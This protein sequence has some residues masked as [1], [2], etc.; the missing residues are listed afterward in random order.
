MGAMLA[1][2]GILTGDEVAA[3][4]IRPWRSFAGLEF[5]LRF[6][7]GLAGDAGQNKVFEPTVPGC[8]RK[9]CGNENYILDMKR[10]RQED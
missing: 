7:I 8:G 5:L 9:T 10:P 3:R 4:P 1:D 2:L 6:R